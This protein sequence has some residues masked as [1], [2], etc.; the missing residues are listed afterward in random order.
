M[1]KLFRKKVVSRVIL[2]GLLILILPAFVMWG[3]ASL[4][5][6]KDKGP[7]YVGIVNNRKVSFDELY[8]AL[9]GVRS[10]VI[11]NYFNQPQIL[12][13]ILKNKPMLAK[14]AWDRI[15]LL[16]EAKRLK[17]KAPDKEVIAFIRSHPLFLRNGAF[18]D[19]FYSYM[20]RNSIGL[21]PRDFEEIVRE[22]LIIQ[23]LSSDITRDIKISD[24]DVFTEYK[25]D[26]SKLK[27][28]YVLLEPK[29]FFDSIKLD[30]NTAKDFY[31]THKNEL[32]LK[33]NLR[34]ALPDRAATFEEA[35]E[36]IEKYLKEAEVRKI[37]R[38]NG[39]DLYA[40]IFKRMQDNNETF[41]KAAGQLKLTVKNT[42]FFSR[43]DKLDEIGD[44]PIIADAGSG[45]K[46]FEVSK[47]VE[48]NKGL[49]IFEVVQ[50][51]DPDEEAFKKDKDEYARKVRE[52]RSN[53]VMEDH[54]RKLEDT[55]KL[56]INLEDVEKYYR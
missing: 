26:F 4:S 17:I 43:T 38:K 14:I 29:D 13:V 2:W 51:K 19:R 5:R 47:P 20:L 27:I 9:S 32:M 31:E 24:E 39:E 23:K 22:N 34:G 10:Q 3:N 16:D 8:M 30:E 40:D 50:K 28:A 6:S 25:K 18:D 48:I 52:M 44:I 33:S 1:L 11:L 46:I 15:L 41:E 55:A 56:V 54:L 53:A 35:K 45:L 36:Q 42:D 21:E 49:I 37:L 12:D 7:N